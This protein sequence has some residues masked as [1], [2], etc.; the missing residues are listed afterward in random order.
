[1][2][3]VEQHGLLEVDGVVILLPENAHEIAVGLGGHWTFSSGFALRDCSASQCE[4][5]EYLPLD[6]A[7]R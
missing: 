5:Q 7:P 1:M 2:G 3:G 4:I 6:L